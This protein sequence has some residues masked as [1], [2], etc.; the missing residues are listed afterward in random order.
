MVF[1]SSSP[2]DSTIPFDPSS[3]S[4]GS[5]GHVVVA[6][7]LDPEAPIG[8]PPVFSSTVICSITVLEGGEPVGVLDGNLF[9]GGT[10]TL[11]I[12]AANL[13][14]C[15]F[16]TIDPSG[17]IQAI[18]QPTGV[19]LLIEKGF[20]INGSP[21]L[22]PQGVFGVTELD[23][24]AGAGGNVDPGKVLTI[25]G[26]DRSARI[27][28]A[29]F[30]DTFTTGD[31]YTVPQCIEQVLRSQAP[32]CQSN[33]EPSDFIPTQQIYAPG[34][35]PWQAI[36]SICQ[37]A[38]MVAYFDANGILVVRS[39][40]GA[41]AKPAVVAIQDGPGN[42][43]NSI[44]NIVTSDPG[45]NGVI[46]VGTNP[47]NND[48]IPAA[49]YDMDPQSPTY[50]LGPYGKRPAPPVTISTVT[51]VGQA[52]IIANAL[53]PQV[54]GLTRTVAMDI[55]PLPFL[56]AYDLVYVQNALAQ[57]NG[58][59]LLQ[60]ATISLDFSVLDN[61]TVVPLGTN[62]DQLLN[63]KGPSDAQ[64]APTSGL[65][66]GG[67]SFI[68]KPFTNDF[69][70]TPFSSNG[71]KVGLPNLPGGGLINP[72]FP[73]SIWSGGRIFHKLRGDGGWFERDAEDDVEDDI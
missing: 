30:D 11:D 33:V 73:G 27:S 17:L 26:T 54:L 6:D 10:V 24:A 45:Y 8:E 71:T 64:F 35:D 29:E 38:G 39:N 69:T 72:N 50:A 56:D 14:T 47:T 25:D 37:A 61:I 49:A 18:L 46:V 67:A 58:T 66:A 53:L 32:W 23:V 51:A 16:Q 7:P 59:F 5:T 2:F 43:A 13:R 20:I 41:T 22:Y 44:T 55:V 40:P 48:P 62:I 52:Q 31:S 57:V 68:F 34:D 65:F 36:L 28:A 3:T 60:L 1:D 9:Q 21:V 4:G 70:F 19:E 12:T 42:F 15:T 63:N